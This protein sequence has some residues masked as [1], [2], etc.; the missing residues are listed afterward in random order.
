MLKRQMNVICPECGGS[1]SPSWN[2]SIMNVRCESCGWLRFAAG[3]WLDPTR[4][5]VYVVPAEGDRLRTIADVARTLGESVVQV[6][7][8][9]DECRPIR[10]EVKAVEVKRLFSG[11]AQ[12][13]AVVETV[14]RFPWL[15]L[16][17]ATNEQWYEVWTEMR[18]DGP[19]LLLVVPSDRGTV[20]VRSPKSDYARVHE[21]TSY[22][23]AMK[24][25][26]GNK[27]TRVSGTI[28]RCD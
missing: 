13:G 1:A 27:C 23:E 20:V 17:N 5:D 6:R 24:W 19:G 26:E 15:L 18:W 7:A 25:L 21:A 3:P 4:Y 11:I 2:D 9:I 12:R 8:M 28:V 10:A 14:P 16:P 22:E